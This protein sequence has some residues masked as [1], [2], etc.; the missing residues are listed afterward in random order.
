[1]RVVKRQ[2]APRKRNLIGYV[3]LLRLESALMQY[4]AGLLVRIKVRNMH[5]HFTVHADLLCDTSKHFKKRLQER[6][7]P[8]EGECSICYE[9][10]DPAVADIT[11]CSAQCGQNMHQHCVDKWM[12]T[13]DGAKTC[14]FCR[15][16]WK[17]RRPSTVTLP[18]KVDLKSEAVQ[19][20]IDWLYS[21]IV[22]VDPDVAPESDD[23]NIQLLQAWAVAAAAQDTPFKNAIIAHLVSQFEEHKNAGFG[24]ASV[25]YA[26]DTVGRIHPPMQAFV[27]QMAL[28][29][30]MPMSVRQA[31][32]GAP[33]R[34]RDEVL[35]STAPIRR[36]VLSEDTGGGYNLEGGQPRQKVG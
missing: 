19:L 18:S 31:T 1:M 25:T 10:L 29:W 6:R 26:F 24:A 34:L 30:G 13:K 9:V 8:V 21:D 20:Y 12:K 28:V 11:F 17:M 7:K 22:R 33:R 32:G 36:N 15:T 2:G 4:S 14:A 16:A 27:K 3:I 23:Y 5:R 35:K